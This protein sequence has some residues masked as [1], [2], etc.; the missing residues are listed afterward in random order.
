MVDP[1]PPRPFEVDE[2]RSAERRRR[3]GQLRFRSPIV[4]TSTE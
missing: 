2:L 3:I 1:P 4:L